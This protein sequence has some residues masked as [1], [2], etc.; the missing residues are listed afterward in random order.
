[1]VVGEGSSPV[2]D[3]TAVANT[4]QNHLSNSDCYQKFVNKKKFR[5][6]QEDL[7]PLVEILSSYHLIMLFF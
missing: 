1:M 7:V 3:V 2:V 4:K 5:V 6:I